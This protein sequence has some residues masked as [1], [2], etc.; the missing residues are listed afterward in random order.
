LRLSP[1]RR[2][3]HHRPQSRDREAASDQAY[4]LHRL[5]VLGHRAH[6]LPDRPAQPVR[7]RDL[8]AVELPHLPARRTADHAFADAEEIK[9][10][11]ILAV[12]LGNWSAKKCPPGTIAGCTLV[13]RFFHSAARSKYLCIR[14]F[15]PQRASVG[16]CT[17]LSRSAASWSRS[18]V[19][20]AR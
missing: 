12:S 5:A 4:R 17:F 11:R 1:R 19:A 9:S 2:S 20:A 3:R 10:S 6:L 13:Q 16:H 7:C 14:P 15:E 18:I 8:V